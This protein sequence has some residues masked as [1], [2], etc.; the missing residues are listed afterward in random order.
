MTKPFQGIYL[1][2]ISRVTE[3]YAPD[4]EW[5][6]PASMV[7]IAEKLGH[8]AESSRWALHATELAAGSPL[9]AQ[10][11]TL[12]M[13]A[14]PQSIRQ[15]RYAEALGFVSQAIAAR[16]A[17]TDALTAFAE[18][19]GDEELRKIIED[20]PQA[21]PGLGT[22]FL[23]VMIVPILIDLL[24]LLHTDS[25][26]GRQFVTSVMATC[27]EL[28]D[29]DDQRDAWLTAH[30]ALEHIFSPTANLD[31]IMAAGIQHSKEYKY[32]PAAIYSLGTAVVGTP[33]SVCFNWLSAL[34]FYERQF[35]ASRLHIQLVAALVNNYWKDMASSSSFAFRQPTLL[36]TKLEEFE[37]RQDLLP[38]HVMRV[39][40]WHLGLAVPREAKEWLEKV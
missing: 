8:Y 15:R 36:R 5:Y 19:R 10:A 35:A 12:L 13:Y 26:A 14:G 18:K 11:K 1:R 16:Q 29:N 3:L 17:P 23:T 39:V 25:S 4:T 22:E 30:E 37:R 34:E 38:R 28:A 2:D 9:G 33:D 20:R 31:S 7:W 6:M 32:L 27:K 24:T 40:A 21:R